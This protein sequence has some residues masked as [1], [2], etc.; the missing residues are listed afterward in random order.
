MGQ[1][2]HLRHRPHGRE[3]HT[4]AR[5]A[6]LGCRTLAVVL[7]VAAGA[8]ARAQDLPARFSVAGVAANDVLNVRA[9]PSAGTD[10]LD[11]LAPDQEGVEVIGLSDDGKWGMVAVP[12]SNGW[13][14]MRYLVAE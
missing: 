7:A 10:I 12:G 3:L 14:A 11:R 8:A 1:H 5:L 2:R 13:V 9:G 6:F 4:Q